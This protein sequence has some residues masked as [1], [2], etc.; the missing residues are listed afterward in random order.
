MT[1]LYLY[2][3][4]ISGLPT[5]C[6]RA[7]EPPGAG[8]PAC[9]DTPEGL[10]AGRGF[11]VLGLPYDVSIWERPAAAAV[12]GGEDD[13]L[14]RLTIRRQTPL[15]NEELRAPVPSRPD[16]D[17]GYPTYRLPRIGEGAGALG[18]LLVECDTGRWPDPPQPG[19]GPASHF[20][21]VTFDAPR[22]G[23]RVRYR[24]P[25]EIYDEPDWQALDLRVREWIA[26][27]AASP[28]P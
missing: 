10:R 15:G 24:F 28:F 9:A 8:G 27:R 2:I 4:S 18:P 6:L 19:R 16:L 3:Q 1:R 22:V 7:G 11:F 23:V 25:R 5:G 26:A 14:R 21:R 13:R 20:C 17:G 12:N